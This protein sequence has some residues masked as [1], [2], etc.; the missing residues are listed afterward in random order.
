[1][2]TLGINDNHPLPATPVVMSDTPETDAELVHVRSDGKFV[3]AKFAEE[4][5]RSRNAAR[6]ET[7]DVRQIL[8]IADEERDE[9][10]ARVKELESNN[11]YQTGYA[12]GE[13]DAHKFMKS[14]AR[15]IKSALAMYEEYL[16]N[17]E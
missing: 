6:K 1:M 12:D 10:L 14:M 8:T 5:E 9:A 2:N 13:S 17:H 7:L 16:K 3:R 11:R 4:M 15:D